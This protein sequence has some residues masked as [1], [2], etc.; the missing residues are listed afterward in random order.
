MN[1]VR[2]HQPNQEAPSRY[3]TASRQVRAIVQVLD[4]FKNF[5]L[6]LFCDIRAIPKRLRYRDDGNT[7]FLGYV[8]E[9]NDHR[10]SVYNSTGIEREG[11]WAENPKEIDFSSERNSQIGCPGSDSF[12]PQKAMSS[13]R[14]NNYA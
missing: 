2:N 3:Q 4:P 9:S 5:R 10:E 13:S 8:F 14:A 11:R 12:N 6:R 7:K 1:Q